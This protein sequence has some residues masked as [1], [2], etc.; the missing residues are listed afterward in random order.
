[1]LEQEGFSLIG[2]KHAQR[3]LDMPPD[4][5]IL[6][7]LGT[8]C[9]RSVDYA[10]RGSKAKLPL[11]ASRCVGPALVDYDVIKPCSKSIAV[12]ARTEAPKR[13]HESRLQRIVCVRTRSQHSHRKTGTCILVAPN[14]V[15]K[16]FNVPGQDGSDQ[17]CICGSFHKSM[18]MEGPVR[19]TRYKTRFIDRSS[20]LA[21]EMET[22]PDDSGC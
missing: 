14:E 3:V 15:G 6:L 11:P 9:Y 5:R 19:V 17:F 16:R 2:G 8:R 4:V 12:P 21:S 18:T 22:G 1:M 13:A 10:R 7:R 20:K